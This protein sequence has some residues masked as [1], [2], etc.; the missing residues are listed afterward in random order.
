MSDL[1]ARITAAISQ[2]RD[3]LHG[4]EELGGWNGHMLASVLERRRMLD[5][6]E[7]IARLHVERTV[8]GDHGL[9]LYDGR[10]WPCDHL[11]AVAA[12]LGINPDQS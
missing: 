4:L 1:S 9:C 10:K 2:Q 12:G 8:G 6:F 5:A 11:L 3:Y 7:Q